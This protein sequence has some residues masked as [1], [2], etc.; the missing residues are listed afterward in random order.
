MLQLSWMSLVSSGGHGS[1]LRI[2]KLIFTKVY[3]PKLL[4]GSDRTS[5]GWF[6]PDFII[7]V[8]FPASPS[9]VMNFSTTFLFLQWRPVGIFIFAFVVS[10]V[11]ESRHGKNLCQ[12]LCDS[13]VWHGDHGDKTEVSP[14]PI[15]RTFLHN[16]TP[17]FELRLE[18]WLL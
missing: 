8:W 3:K 2:S 13:L 1:D 10:R 4:V 15:I 5:S 6:S 11:V 9:P 16:Q 14:D 7:H 17:S 12:N 18:P